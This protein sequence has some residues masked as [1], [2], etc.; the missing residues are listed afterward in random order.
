[1]D[2]FRRSKTLPDLG[3]SL[4]PK[5]S[6]A[7]SISSAQSPPIT[8]S[9]LKGLLQRRTSSYESL[10]DF[11]T[12]RG[13]FWIQLILY[14]CLASMLAAGVFVLKSQSSPGI[15]S[16]ATRSFQVVYTSE[17]TAGKD[18]AN[19]SPEQRTMIP[20][21][22]ATGA[23]PVLDALTFRPPLLY[24]ED[25]QKGS[26]SSLDEALDRLP[27][28]WE[29][30][31]EQCPSSPR[32][33]VFVAIA[34]RASVA[35]LPK[36]NMIR[37]TWMQDIATMHAD[38]I[39]AQFLVS[40]PTK[41][42]AEV[43]EDLAMEV[44]RYGDLAVVPGVEDYYRLPEKTI[45]M[46]RYALSSAC[47]YTH[48]LKT[49]DDVYM[50]PAYLLDVIDRGLFDGAL[51]IQANTNL[52]YIMQKRKR[53]DGPGRQVPWM[54]KMFV[55]KVD[56]NVTGSFPGFE[57][58]RDP[59]NKWYLSEEEYPDSLGPH[60]VRWIS[61]WGYAMSRDVVQHAVDRVLDKG[62]KPVW[63]GR[64][65]WEDVAMAALLQDYA[66][67]SHL[68]SFKAAWDTCTNDTVLKHLD[69][70]AML[71]PGLHELDGNGVWEAHTV[72]CSAGM[73]EE[74]EYEEWRTWRNKQPDTAANGEM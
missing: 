70:Q 34:S 6:S 40:Q 69:N 45:A 24:T 3:E 65:P 9:K 4:L 25:R 13:Y 11:P 31:V 21:M 12:S 42:V 17:Y 72:P 44:E 60:R 74:G 46:M 26:P 32:V 14:G 30:I 63:F 48:V 52:D 15:P 27:Y 29:P 68:D 36:R 55:G 62:P 35:G 7:S 33:R 19:S 51:Q 10:S 64:M 56:R 53:R 39:K 50:R 16:T 38:R 54:D 41:D 5:T 73:Y 61:G 20:F 43:A 22:K 59:R 67:L 18:I 8:T 71:I 47:D 49:D 37:E 23:A 66:P 28:R 1:M 58:V 57:A 2:R